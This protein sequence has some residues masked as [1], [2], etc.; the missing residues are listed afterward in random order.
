MGIPF[1]LNAIRARSLV[2]VYLTHVCTFRVEQVCG[3]CLCASEENYRWLK[4]I[5]DVIVWISQRPSLDKFIVRRGSYLQWYF[6]IG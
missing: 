6:Y 3:M 5:Q 4:K 2:G 1:L